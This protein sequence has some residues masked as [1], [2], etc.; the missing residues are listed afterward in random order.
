MRSSRLAH[1]SAP[2]PWQRSQN[3]PLLRAANH[4]A[5][6]AAFYCLCMQNETLENTPDACTLSLDAAAPRAASR[7]AFPG[8]RLFT[9]QAGSLEVSGDTYTLIQGCNVIARRS[10]NTTSHATRTAKFQST[11]SQFDHVASIYLPG[12]TLSSE[13]AM[14]CELC[15]LSAGLEPMSY[16]P[17]IASASMCLFLPALSLHGQSVYTTAHSKPCRNGGN[18]SL[19]AGMELIRD[20]KG[21]KEIVA[22]IEDLKSRNKVQHVHSSGSQQAFRL[23]SHAL[24][25]SPLKLINVLWL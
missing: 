15:L 9:T 18:R 17:S 25:G 23:E 10:R 20:Q 11:Y 7:V 5:K 8:N 22:F 21:S 24:L 3:N 16:L 1:K 6:T 19:R 2:G 13:H 12:E 4:E 14:I